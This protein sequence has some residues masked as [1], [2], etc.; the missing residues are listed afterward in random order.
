[1][2][3]ISNGVHRVIMEKLGNNDIHEFVKKFVKNMQTL[4]QKKMIITKIQ[5]EN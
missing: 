2:N 5:L 3:E 4:R 1:M